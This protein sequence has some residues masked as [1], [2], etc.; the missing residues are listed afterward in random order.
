MYA[1]TKF[2]WDF[3]NITIV[4]LNEDTYL[5]SQEF[6]KSSEIVVYIRR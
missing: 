6:V 2:T 1:F 5:I 3:Q 4:W